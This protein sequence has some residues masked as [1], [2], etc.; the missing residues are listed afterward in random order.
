[1]PKPSRGQNYRDF[2]NSCVE[3][4]ITQENREPD[5]ARAI[6]E[7]IWQEN[8]IA[9]ELIEYLIEPDVKNQ[10]QETYNDYPKA[11]SDN[12]KRALKYKKDSGN[13]KGCGTAVGWTRATQLAKR[14][15]I[16]R[17]T[18]ARMSAFAR[19]RQN[20]KVPYSEGCGGL[21][22]DCW[23]G[24]EGIAWAEKKLKEID[25]K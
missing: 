6:C 2:I 14:K 22:W 24:D 7:S 8:K 15:S 1:M 21:M 12:A 25:N 10:K 3:E 19:H 16:S 13:P 18:I 20:S 17:D 23:G 4:L 11:A 5:Q 9:T